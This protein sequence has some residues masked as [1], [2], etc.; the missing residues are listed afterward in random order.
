MRLI[1]RIEQVVVSLGRPASAA[2]L[3]PAIDR[4]S[5][6]VST[7]LRNADWPK[8]PGGFYYPP[9][10]TPHLLDEAEAALIASVRTGGGLPYVLTPKEAQV[11]DVLRAG[12]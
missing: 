12:V 7:T 2:E 3:A 4:A 1:D 8:A 6:T 11:V 9:D 5:S 10:R